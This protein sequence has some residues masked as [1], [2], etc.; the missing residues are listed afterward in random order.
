ML[1]SNVVIFVEGTNARLQVWNI[2]TDELEEHLLDR[3]ISSNAK[4]HLF[5][6]TG[7]ICVAEMKNK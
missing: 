6:E 5:E 3:K 1:G 4:L 7:I 2:E